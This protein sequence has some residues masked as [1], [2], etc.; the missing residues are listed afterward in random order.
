MS[1]T[2]VQHYLRR[3]TDFLDG[4]SY[5]TEE[6]TVAQSS[7]L[8]A[9]HAAIS[10]TDA[11]RVGLRE[12]KVTGDDHRLAADE[13]E[14]LLNHK[15]YAD[16]SGLRHLRGLISKKSDIAYGRGNVRFQD[17]QNLVFKAKNFAA[18]ANKMGSDLK[19][20]GWRDGSE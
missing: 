9:V 17:C 12:G 14:S 2:V 13:L 11:L 18:W 15:R 10:Y 3:A 19:I 20:E 7:A 5:M 1:A 6:E 8:L 16:R 4:M